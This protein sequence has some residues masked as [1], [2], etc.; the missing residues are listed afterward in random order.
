MQETHSNCYSACVSKNFFH[1]KILSWKYGNKIHIF[2]KSDQYGCIGL[3]ELMRNEGSFVQIGCEMTKLWPFLCHRYQL[4]NQSIYDVVT[5]E[6]TT[7]AS[8]VSSRWRQYHGVHGDLR[9][10][11]QVKLSL[12]TH[13]LQGCDDFIFTH[14]LPPIP[15]NVRIRKNHAPNS[16]QWYSSLHSIC[17]TNCITRLYQTH[18]TPKSFLNHFYNSFCKSSSP[19]SQNREIGPYVKTKKSCRNASTNQMI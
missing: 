1:K 13:Q 4:I 9:S 10:S 7:S 19:P 6:M 16:S 15:G 3:D 12:S 18:F 5:K 8:L 17:L 11:S 14:S 2:V